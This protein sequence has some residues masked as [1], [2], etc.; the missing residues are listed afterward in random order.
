[1]RPVRAAAG[2][3]GASPFV[4]A[5]DGISFAAILPEIIPLAVI[6]VPLRRSTGED[7]KGFRR[8]IAMGGEG[9]AVAPFDLT[10]VAFITD[11]GVPGSEAVA[12]FQTASCIQPVVGTMHREGSAGVH[13]LSVT[14]VISSPEEA[15]AR[16]LIL[17]TF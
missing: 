5:E 9:E 6:R 17:R 8:A 4:N 7:F 13:E 11:D 12:A 2:E 14:L 3:D 16:E 10:A 1:M 15:H